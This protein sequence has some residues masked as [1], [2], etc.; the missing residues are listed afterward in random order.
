MIV[1]LTVENLA[2]IER[3]QIRLGEGFTVLTGETGAG[4]SLL[5]DAIQLVLGGR[6]ETEL[7]RTGSAKAS[8]SV[9]I[10]LKSRPEVA[11]KCSELGFDPEENVL[12]L[13]REVFAEGRSQARIMGRTAPASTLRQIGNLLVDL[14]GQHDHQSLLDVERHVEFLDAWIGLPVV[15]LKKSVFEAFDALEGKRKQLSSLRSSLRD[16][17]QRIDLLRYQ[18]NEIEAANPIVGE[19]AE[20]ESQMARLKHSEKLATATQSSAE[21]L[22][23]GES[24][25]Q[26]LIGDAA[27]ALE[28]VLRYDATLEPIIESIRTA[29]IYL[30]EAIHSLHGYVES[31]DAEP[32]LIDI[33]ADRID[34]LRRMRRKYGDDEATVLAFLETA[35]AELNLLD[36]AE[37]NE[38]DLTQEIGRLEQGLA[39]VAQNLS[40][41]RKVRSL[42]FAKLVETTLRDLAMEKARFEVNFRAKPPMADGCDVVEFYFSANLGEDP[43]ALSKIASGGEMSRV[44]LAIKTALAGR[45]GVPTLI[46]D[47]VDAGL[48]GRAAASVARQ[49][50]ALASN[51]QVLVISHL[52]QIASRA[53]SH[54]RIEKVEESGRVQTRVVALNPRDRIEEVARML[55]GD[56]VT[57]RAL[58][59]ARELLRLS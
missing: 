50:E 29:S 43:K 20:L 47:E 19:M 7:V 6:A 26:D 9:A 40:E 13:Q 58:E 51:Y 30:Q 39:E 45:A 15:E 33:V 55:A 1:E 41:L 18:I 57:D 16:R 56:H 24:N 8:V 46:F 53:S 10:D 36:D 35:R 14:H 25:A 4:K 34:L 38:T 44:M 17:E 3:A 52:P 31:L 49:L 2:I 21:N 42:E 11:A 12:H 5:I 28:D 54:F 48:S 59:N 37:A 23:D 32:G 27:K 22:S